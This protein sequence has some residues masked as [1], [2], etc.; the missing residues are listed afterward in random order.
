[1][2]D[3]KFADDMLRV[4][5]FI[6]AISLEGNEETTDGRRGTGVYQAVIRATKLL[7]ERKL[8]LALAA[9]IQALTG[10]P[11]LVKNTSKR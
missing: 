4:K 3:E 9:V 7:K 6:P 10:M 1:M 11:S 2:I 8:P 5:N